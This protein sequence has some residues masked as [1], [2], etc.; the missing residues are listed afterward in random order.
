MSELFSDRGESSEEDEKVAKR[1]RKAEKTL[2]TRLLDPWERYRGLN[3]LLDAYV[4]MMEIADRKTRFSLVILG[5]LN[6]FNLVIAARPDLF[7]SS[8]IAPARWIGIYAAAYISVSLYLVIQAIAALRPRASM[9]LGRVQR[10]APAAER[11]PGLRFIGDVVNQTTEQYYEV[12]KQAEV[13]QLSRE[14]ALHVQ[15][16]ARINIDKYQALN[17]VYQGLSALAV[18]TVV[19]VLILVYRGLTS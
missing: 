6:A 4:D 18:L 15:S 2:E 10:V 8:P 5:A 11:L 9:F 1:L 12:W 19:L 13:G 7:A 3:D 14:V 17:R 16:L